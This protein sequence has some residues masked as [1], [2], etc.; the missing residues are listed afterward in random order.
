MRI[1]LLGL[2]L[3]V[4]LAS[5]VPLPA[6]A[7]PATVIK[8]GELRAK[9]FLDAP[10]SGNV[11]ADAEVDTLGSEGAWTQVKTKDGKTGW[12]RMLNLRPKTAAS[13]G[14]LSGIGNLGN[15]ARTGSTGATATTGAKGI[16]KEDLA[17]AAPS[18]AEVKRLDGYRASADDAQRYA[19]AQKLTARAVEI[20]AAPA[21][22]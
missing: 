1:P 2:G 7:A 10:V 11:A 16:S 18:E 19:R 9:P 8:A 4:P 22:K 20:P 6:Q 5:L 3:L 13:G 12:L 15:V 21:T 17:K 14:A